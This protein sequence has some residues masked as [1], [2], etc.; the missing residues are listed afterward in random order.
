MKGPVR[1]ELEQLASGLVAPNDLTS[2]GDD[3]LFVNQQD[4]R[5]RIIKSGTLLATPFLD[6]S[7]RLI[8]STGERGLLGLAF[9]PDYNNAASPGFRKF[10][11]YTSE[12][13]TGAA[14]FTVPKSTAFDHQSVVAEWQV[15]AGNP[16][17]AD[18]ATRR[19][20]LR[21]D[22]PQPNHNGGKIA[23]RPGEP[24]L[25]ISLGDGGG[26]RDVGD[27]HTPDLGNGQ[28]LTNV[29]GAILRIDPLDPGLT[30]GSADPI[31]A[32]GKY[33]VPA[34]NPFINSPTAVEEI[35]AYGFR[36]PF[37]FSFDEPTG[38]LIVGDV[39]QANIEE[40]DFVEAGKNYGWNRKEGSFLFNKS[41]STITPD[42]N[43]DPALTNP[44]L[45]Y[46]HEDGVAVIGGFVLRG[47][48]VPALIGQY[49]FGDY[50]NPVT[51]TGRLFYSDFS[52]GLTQELRL[53][54]PERDLGLLLKGFGQDAN[55]EVYALG[56]SNGVG[57]VYKIVSVPAN[58]TIVNLSTRL[59]V[60]TSDNV[61]IGG[62]IVTGSDDVEV[63]L[64]GIGP[65]LMV[66]GTL[67]NPMLELRDVGGA[68]IASNDDW[69]NGPDK[70]AIIDLGLAPGD[71]AESAILAELAPGAYTTIMSDAG[72]AT[73]NGLVELF[74]TNPATPANPANISTR[75]FVQT[76]D[77]VM[78]GG[79]ILTGTETR[80]LLLRAIGPSLGAFGVSDAL[81]DPTLDLHDANGA[82][83]RSNN[84]WRDTQEGEIAAT[85]IPPTDDRESAIVMD[86]APSNYTAIVR[87]VNG[88][89]GVAL[90]EA[91][92]V[93]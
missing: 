10:Y 73:G 5:I 49:I 32:N 24:Y 13:V 82:L 57:I 64:R 59:S 55:G 30:G 45:E 75:G 87:G 17:L 16:D 88:T 26:G 15:S 63:V 71:N 90:V 76:G 46:S 74:A 69:M 39:G 47:T 18:P 37:R 21:I 29:L 38:R 72:G 43:P 7:A 19:E 41:N 89:T 31:S 79:F 80:R 9:H 36:N 93:E 66:P 86:L 77:D 20:V 25:Y 34:G 58:P 14:D 78:I 70:D 52:G 67:P 1:I 84:N 6:V 53:G 56:D 27:G 62:F 33:R 50:L 42:P 22:Q 3:R 65:S 61:L 11:T 40:V 8:A 54:D 68:L 48:A 83:I 2:V 12:P 91:Y 85:G 51:G 81:L 28:D 23:F 4:G 92:D 60:G 35:Y 44:V